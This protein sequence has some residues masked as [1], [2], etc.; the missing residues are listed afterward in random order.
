MWIPETGVGPYPHIGT[1]E[2][3]IGSVFN[4]GLKFAGIHYRDILCG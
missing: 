2:P 3:R 1:I 4:N